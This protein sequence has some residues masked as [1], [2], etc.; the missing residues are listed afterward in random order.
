MARSGINKALV[1]KAREEVLKKGQNP[2]IDT[3]AYFCL[4]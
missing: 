3:I 1:L 4:L 2:S